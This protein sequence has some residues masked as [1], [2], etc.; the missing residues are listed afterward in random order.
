[1]VHSQKMPA[2]GMHV[3]MKHKHLMA[4]FVCHECNFNAPFADGIVAHVDAVHKASP[5]GGMA[6][7][8]CCKE[9]V[10]YGNSEANVLEDHYR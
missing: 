3:H 5:Q 9:M 6:T 10:A 1:M 8:P 2:C 7:C 4:D